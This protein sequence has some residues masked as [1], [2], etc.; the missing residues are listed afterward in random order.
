MLERFRLDGRVAVITGGA[1]GIGLAIVQAFLDAGAGVVLADIDAPALAIAAAELVASGGFVTTHLL[2]VTVCD[3]VD[4]SVEA[5]EDRHGDVIILVNNAGIAR[6]AAS[7]EV[8][9]AQ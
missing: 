6:N 7:L 3:A 5:I 1:R 9:D 4:A 2:D 8:D